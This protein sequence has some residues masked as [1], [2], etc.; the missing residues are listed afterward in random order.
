MDITAGILSDNEECYRGMARWYDELYGFRDAVDLQFWLSLPG[1]P[2]MDILELGCGTGRVSIPLACNG[3]NVTGL[4][5]S[6]SMLAQLRAK[7]SAEEQPVQ[8]R[9][10]VVQGSMADFELD[11]RYDL[12]IIPFRAFMHLISRDEQHSCLAAVRRH[13]RED[14]RLVFDLFDPNLAFIARMAEACSTWRQDLETETEDGGLLRRYTRIL[15]DARSQVHDVSMRFERL[16]GKGRVVDND[17]EQFRMRWMMHNEAE[18]L[19]E[20]S[21]LEIEAV[22]SDYERSPLAERRGE[23]IYSCRRGSG[24]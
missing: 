11:A 8:Q 23:L 1:R 17:E 19:L 6:S 4:D 2:A 10:H 20:G 12:V 3:H 16:D 18:L 15:A 24:D 13:L 22:Y 14:G 5:L 7:L 9:L 21:G